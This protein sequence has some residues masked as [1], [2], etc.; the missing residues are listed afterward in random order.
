[1]ELSLILGEGCF[2][3]GSGAGSQ[4]GSVFAPT[5]CSPES[6]SH[7]WPLELQEPGRTVTTST[8]LVM[9][10]SGGEG[11]KNK[12][13]TPGQLYQPKGDKGRNRV[14]MR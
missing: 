4:L 8:P 5:V 3:G 2:P 11:L 14:S 12:M 9:R 1:M 10:A 13:R 6:S 7:L